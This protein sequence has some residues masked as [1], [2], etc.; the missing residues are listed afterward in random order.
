MRIGH[1][2]IVTCAVMKGKPPLKFTWLKDGRNIK[3]GVSINNIEKASNLVIDPIVKLSSGNYTCI[4]ENAFGKNSYS[5]FLRVKGMLCW[6]LSYRNS[7]ITI[8]C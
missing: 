5:A 8:K 6:F 2:I 1:N 4:S 3:G 7:I